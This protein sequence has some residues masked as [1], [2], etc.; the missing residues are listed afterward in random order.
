M[1]QIVEVRGDEAG[2]WLESS[3]RH[4]V[5]ETASANPGSMVLL[6]KMAEALFVEA[7]RRYMAH[8]PPEQTGWLAGARDP[9]VGAAL[10]VLHRDP[11]RPWTV[12]KLA[13]EVGTSRTVLT[14]RFAHFLGEP[15]INYLSR[16]RL[17]L[18][19]R[20]LEGGHKTMLQVAMDVGYGSEAAFSRAFKREFGL[21]PAQYRKRFAERVGGEPMGPA[22]S[23]HLSSHPAPEVSGTA[24]A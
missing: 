5:L 2:E 16:W 6:S 24:S 3:I 13:A 10:A 22:D 4:L 9:V 12:P 7:L 11:C 18:A 17:Q 8:L 19:A 21:P 23:G 1:P 20:L 14:E 15:P